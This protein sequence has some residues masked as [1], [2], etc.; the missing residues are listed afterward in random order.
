MPRRSDGRPVELLVTS[1]LRRGTQK[2]WETSDRRTITGNFRLKFGRS[3]GRRAPGPEARARGPRSQ[4]SVSYRRTAAGPGARRPMMICL[5]V[6]FKF[7]G[8][9][10][11]KLPANRGKDSEARASEEAPLHGLLGKVFAR[12][13]VTAPTC[14]WYRQ[15]R[16]TAVGARHSHDDPGPLSGRSGPPFVWF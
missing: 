6:T 7:P 10:P 15:G 5:L 9:L 1:G 14:L 11:L 12:M 3:D 4:W 8:P 2:S 16:S 13:S